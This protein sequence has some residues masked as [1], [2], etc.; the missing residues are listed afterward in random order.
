LL[1]GRAEALAG[2]VPLAATAPRAASFP[3]LLPIV[4][5]LAM[6]AAI[7][8][9]SNIVQTD[10]W[11]G[12]VSGREVALH[13]LPSIEHLTLLSHGRTWVDQQWLAQLLLYDAD[14]VGGVGLVVAV[15]AA[16]AL[17]SFALA[18]AA[19]QARGASPAAL[20]LWLP[21]AFL[22]GPWGV[23]A[24]TQSLALPLLGLVLWLILRD[25]DV[26]RRSSL[27]LLAVLCVWANIHGSVT[28]AA[29]VVCAH[30]LQALVSTGLR[31]L[32]FALL[33]VAP[34]TVLASPYARAL[35]GY[36]RTML[37]HPPYG[38]Q[39]VEWQRTAPA[40]APFF[41]G[42]AIVV[43]LVLFRARRRLVPAEVLI[44][45]LTFA[46]GLSAV[47]LTP[48]FGLAMLAVA[49]RLASRRPAGAEFRRLAPT[50]VA[51]VLLLAV[52]AGLAWS[53]RRDYDGPARLFAALDRQPQAAR[54]YA[55]LPL[56]DWALW[57]DPSLR[58]RMAY[59]GRPELM[60]PEQFAD[61]IRFARLTPGWPTVLRG[62]SLVLTNRAIARRLARSGWRAIAAADG[63]V[64]LRRHAPAG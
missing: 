7:V 36:Y 5:P 9:A 21:L 57:N 4:A 12:L 2:A 22:V 6:V 33:L 54:V 60:T 31:R 20:A 35:P 62:Y 45:A 41:V 58:G 18:A 11:V 1:R 43:A 49:P 16:A 39:I 52:G 15:C 29:A 63:V 38:R 46:A 25:P 10:T 19:A 26:R 48:W 13:G 34:A 24:R 61:V 44:L 56:T 27:W 42:A 8:C 30:A 3:L 28:L 40:N 55:D 37:L 17:V 51:A 50:L 53:A 23:Q 64:V 32:P 59:D 47:R 14:R